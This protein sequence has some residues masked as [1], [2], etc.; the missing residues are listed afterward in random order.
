MDGKPRQRFPLAR[1]RLGGA[2]FTRIYRQGRR[3]HGALF[4]V[5]VLENGREHTR[6]GLSVSKRR[7]R[8][9]VDRNRV[10]RV[11]REAFRLSLAALPAGIDV[12]MIATVDRLE[13]ELESTRAELVALVGRALKKRARG[14]PQ[15][16]SPE[17]GAGT[18]T[19]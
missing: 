17:S 18:V 12:I 13:P 3:A 8:L 7:A 19:P 14:V 10:R 11:F 9:A 1:H 5:V 4:E 2:D 15:R 6:L 16:A